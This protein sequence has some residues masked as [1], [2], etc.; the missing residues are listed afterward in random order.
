MIKI[1]RITS[2][3]II[4]NSLICH[5]YYYY[6]FLYLCINFITDCL[7]GIDSDDD[8]I[9]IYRIYIMTVCLFLSFVVIIIA[10]ILCSFILISLRFISPVSCSMYL[11]RGI[12]LI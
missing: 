7:L 1:Y 8:M 2:S 10:I 12:R 3:E 4:L 5:Y 6:Y 11:P 9:K